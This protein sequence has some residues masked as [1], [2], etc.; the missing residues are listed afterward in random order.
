MDGWFG[1]G[2]IHS[3]TNCEKNDNDDYNNNNFDNTE[4][5]EYNGTAL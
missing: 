1:G 5:I 2:L 4:A 3:I